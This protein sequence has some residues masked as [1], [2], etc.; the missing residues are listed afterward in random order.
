MKGP[1]GLCQMPGCR[2]QDGMAAVF[3]VPASGEPNVAERPDGFF[4][5][6]VLVPNGHHR[7]PVAVGIH[8]KSGEAIH[9]ASVDGVVP[10]LAI[11]TPGVEVGETPVNQSFGGVS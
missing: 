2:G 4:E 11:G 5:G 9:I 1:A 6:L 8:P 10:A 3:F 7:I